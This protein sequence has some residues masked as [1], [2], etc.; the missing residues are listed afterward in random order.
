MTRSRPCTP[1]SVWTATGK[2]LSTQGRG[3]DMARTL[4]VAVVG[5]TGQVGAVM[6]RLLDERD[7]PLASIR[8]LASARSA[9]STLPWRGEDIVVEDVATAD[10]SGID[11]ALFS[12]GATASRAHA[13]R[14]AAAGAVVVDNSSAWRQHPQVPLVVS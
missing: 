3:A 2:P 11:V 14:F 9:G 7:F 5:A 4:H 8:S 6:R 12:A 13:E 10:L 1:R